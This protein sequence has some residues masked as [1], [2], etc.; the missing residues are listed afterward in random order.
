MGKG[1]KR[2]GQPRKRAMDALG[3]KAVLVGALLL[4]T[5]FLAPLAYQAL[6]KRVLVYRVRHDYLEAV[7]TLVSK[8]VSTG[9]ALRVVTH[10]GGA[11]RHQSTVYWPRVGYRYVVNRREY[12]SAELSP[13]SEPYAERAAAELILARYQVGAQ[14]P[15]WYDPKR[16]ESAFLE[17]P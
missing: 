11:R 14:Y 12:T 9:A 8:E 5:V 2:Q 17:R 7:C 10:P 1:R 4:L 6:K 16:P 15:C 13:T 3:T